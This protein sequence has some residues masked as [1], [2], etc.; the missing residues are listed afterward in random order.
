MGPTGATGSTG[1]TGPAG[2]AGERG[3]TG[4]AGE[5]GSMGPTGATGPTGP[6]GEAG[7]RGEVGPVAATIPFSLSNLWGAGAQI[8]SDSEGMPSVIN[9]VGFGG[10]TGVPK[11]LSFGEWNSGTISFSESDS[12]GTSFILPFDG[13]LENIYVQFA[14]RSSL[15]LE[16]GVTM[17]PFVCLA[18]A[19]NDDMVFRILPETMTY[20]EPYTGAANYPPYSIRK[21]SLTD[22][23]VNIAAGTLVGIV[24]GW[25]G[26]GVSRQMTTQVS[27]SGG[28]FIE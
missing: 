7:A 16:A 2:W 11:Q 15:S 8:S 28:I 23:D 3:A 21:G 25:S 9:F 27:V 1:T 26:E 24:I 12:Y 19:E 6:T 10:D 17:R 22:I 13:I 20:T 14:T 5:A 4:P 18:V